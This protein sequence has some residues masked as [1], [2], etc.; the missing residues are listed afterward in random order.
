MATGLAVG[1]E[2][3]PAGNRRGQPDWINAGSKAGQPTDCGHLF[4]G[5]AAW[6]PA[7]GSP[8]GTE[9]SEGGK[10]GLQAGPEPQGR[11]LWPVPGI[12]ISD[13]GATRISM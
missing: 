13:Q 7:T 6:A 3:S 9:R 11:H 2:Q 10:R 5:P 12:P 8:G 4:L 1:R